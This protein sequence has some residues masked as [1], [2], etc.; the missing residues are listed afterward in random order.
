MCQLYLNKNNLIKKKK[1]EIKASDKMLPIKIKQTNKQ[2]QQPGKQQHH[3]V[4]RQLVQ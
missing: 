4:E 3:I 2:K 1:K